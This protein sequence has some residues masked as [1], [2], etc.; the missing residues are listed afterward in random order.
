MAKKTT[1][2]TTDLDETPADPGATSGRRIEYMPLDEVKN[3][4]ANPKAHDVDTITDSVARFGYIDAVAIDERTGY[5]ISGHGRMKTLRAARDAG[6]EPPEGVRVTDDGTWLVPVQRGWV[7][8]SDADAKAALIA[9]NRTTELGGW[10]DDALLGLL[11]DLSDGGTDVTGLAGV[12]YGLD[13]LQELRDLVDATSDDPGDPWNDRDFQERPPAGDVERGQVWRVGDH[14]LACGDSRDPEVW[15]RMLGERRAD[16]VFADPPYGIDYTGGVGV[17]REVLEGDGSID[18]A[19]QL[20]GDVIDTLTNHAVRP[21]ACLYVSLGQGD[22]FPAMANVLADRD[23]YRWML[24]WVKDTATF[25]RADY[26]QR[27]EPIVYGWWPGGAHHA[28]ED[29]TESSVWELPRP[30]NSD[31]HPT[32]K[33]VELVQRAVV[34]ST[35]PGGIV[36]D[37]FAGSASTLVAAARSGRLGVG[38]EWEPGYVRAALDRLA[39]ETGEKPVLLAD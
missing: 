39:A 22:A 8:R 20:L 19:T 1:P 27:H 25:G 28:V 7:S 37:P 12:G 29:R 36:L 13:D 4:P 18:E 21:G 2:A 14:L 24:V 17:E 30:K 15:E 31:L 11:E 35:H 16:L 3:H 5:L 33:P 26:H 38:C 10:V 23:L 9:L 34:N 6:Q 32:S